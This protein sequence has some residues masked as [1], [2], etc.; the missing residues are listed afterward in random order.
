MAS[1][2]SREFPALRACFGL[3][4]FRFCLLM[5]SSFGG[6]EKAGSGAGPGPS[7]G[8]GSFQAKSSLDEGE[9]PRSTTKAA[10]EDG[11]ALP[12]GELAGCF[13][14]YGCGS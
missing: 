2:V 6:L 4:G 14:A 5:W 9:R 8:E 1:A 3:P 11:A 12:D 7:P 10:L 13:G